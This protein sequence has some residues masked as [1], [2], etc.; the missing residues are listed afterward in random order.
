MKISE[1]HLVELDY[2]LRVA[3]GEVVES[4]EQEGPLQYLHGNGEIP[5][6]L[7]NELS[8]K[9]SGEKFEPQKYEDE[10]RQA[11]LAAVDQKVAGEEVVIAPKA[12][13]KEQI[14]DL[15]AALK[16]SLDER[17][18]A[19]KKPAGKARTRKPAKGKNGSSASRKKASRS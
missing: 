14:I 12:E 7:E 10:F 3:D 4:S 16:Q 15:M 11:V 17:R 1:G 5:E 18:G 8:G 19:G 13:A 6:K 2:I 9:I